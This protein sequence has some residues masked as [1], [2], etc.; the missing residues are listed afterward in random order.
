MIKFVLWFIGREDGISVLSA[1]QP[2][3]VSSPWY[4]MDRATIRS[5]A[6]SP[7]LKCLLYNSF[8]CVV[9]S[10]CKDVH[11]CNSLYVSHLHPEHRYFIPALLDS[12]VCGLRCCQLSLTNSD[13]RLVSRPSHLA[14]ISHFYPLICPGS[15]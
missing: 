11:N 10:G 8:G 4:T 2:Y 3:V 12:W 13:L 15:S 6:L 9:C 7:L 5:S 1:P 14:S